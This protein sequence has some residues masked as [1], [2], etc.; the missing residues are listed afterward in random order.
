ML[1]ITFVQLLE[2]PFTIPVPTQPRLSLFQL[3]DLVPFLYFPVSLAS[4]LNLSLTSLTIVR[5]LSTS[6]MSV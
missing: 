2:Y 4:H 1:S 5:L 6:A 3:F